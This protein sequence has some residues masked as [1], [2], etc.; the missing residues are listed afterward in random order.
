MQS[1]HRETRVLTLVKV[2]IKKRGW[3]AGCLLAWFVVQLKR[4]AFSQKH[5]LFPGAMQA[6]RS[7]SC[8]VVACMQPHHDSLSFFFFSFF[9]P[10]RRH[11]IR[12]EHAVCCRLLQDDTQ[13]PHCLKSIS[14]LINKNNFSIFYMLTSFRC[15]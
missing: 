6:V 5:W 9:S 7:S 10:C 12:C 1:F 15:D 2:T 8:I 11:T 13:C 14:Y 3:L 4:V